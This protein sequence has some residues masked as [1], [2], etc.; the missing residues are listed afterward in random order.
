MEKCLREGKAATE[1]WRN[2][3]MQGQTSFGPSKKA[4]AKL[5]M[6]RFVQAESEQV[7]AASTMA[8]RLDSTLDSAIA[9]NEPVEDVLQA[10]N[11]V[12]RQLATHSRK[13]DEQAILEVDRF[14]K[15]HS[16]TYRNELLQCA[17]SDVS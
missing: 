10:V 9:D 13:A 2:G 16:Q 4:I 17:T 6:Q 3:D 11:A 12:R 7:S 15:E 5:Q 1:R 8:D 14:R